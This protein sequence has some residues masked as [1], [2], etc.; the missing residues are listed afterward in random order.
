MCLVRGRQSSYPAEMRK[1][2]LLFA[3]V[4][5]CFSGIVSAATA[6]DYSGTCIYKNAAGRIGYSGKCSLNFGIVGMSSN[7]R[8]ILQFQKNSIEISG[9]P[10]NNLCMANAVPCIFQNLPGSK[11]MRIVT[12][13]GE[14]FQFSSPPPDSM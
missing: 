14:V 10:K 1:K 5:A 7:F 9:F 3:A 4:F 2:S 8:Y 13:E 12:G 11:L 6:T